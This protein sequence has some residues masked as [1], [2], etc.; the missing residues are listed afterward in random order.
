MCSWP[1]AEDQETEYPDGDEEDKSRQGY[2]DRDRQSPRDF[3]ND[4]TCSGVISFSIHHRTRFFD[5]P[6]YSC[7]LDNRFCYYGSRIC[8]DLIVVVPESDTLHL[9]ITIIVA[10]VSVKPL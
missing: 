6:K 2:R 5:C 3:H 8:G 9:K 4:L 1:L 10:N 7:A